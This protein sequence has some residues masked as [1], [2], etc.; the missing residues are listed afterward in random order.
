LQLFV[1]PFEPESVLRIQKLQ[2]DVSAPSLCF[3]RYDDLHLTSRELIARGSSQFPQDYAVQRSLGGVHSD[4]I[5]MHQ[6]KEAEIRSVMRLCREWPVRPVFAVTT[7]RS[8][9]MPIAVLFEHLMF[10]RRR[11]DRIRRQRLAVTGDSAAS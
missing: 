1:Y 7:K 8:V 4:V 11:E 9:E 6:A 10:D 3:W 5:V 2:S